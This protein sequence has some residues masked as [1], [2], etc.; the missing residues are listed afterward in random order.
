M[1]AGMIVVAA[2]VCGAESGVDLALE[3]EAF[4]RAFEAFL[5]DLRAE[6]SGWRPCDRAAGRSACT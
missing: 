2:E 3:P 5:D 1:L 4:G 6:G